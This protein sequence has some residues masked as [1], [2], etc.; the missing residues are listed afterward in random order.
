MSS[1][2]RFSRE[3]IEAIA[4]S[5]LLWLNPRQLK[6]PRATSVLSIVEKLDEKGQLVTSFDFPLGTSVRGKKILGQFLF[7]PVPT[8]FIDRSLEKDGPRFRFTLAHELGH[9]ALHRRLKL[10]FGELDKPGIQDT[11]ADFHLGR[12]QRV[13]NRDWLEWQANTFAAAL[14]L[15]RATL[16]KAIVEKQLDLGVTHNLGRIFVDR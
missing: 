10:N 3:D 16:W 1:V 5:T 15:P 14:L 2:Q 12:R 13:T 8:I 4:E 9:F 7:E 11:R 6:S